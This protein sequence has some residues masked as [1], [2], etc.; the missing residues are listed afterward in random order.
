MT[1]NLITQSKI[2]PHIIWN[3]E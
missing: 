3:R 2:I 1:Y